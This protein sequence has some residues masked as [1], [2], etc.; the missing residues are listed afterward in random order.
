MLKEK[1]VVKKVYRVKRDDRKDKSSNLNSINEKLIDM[2]STLA[3]NAKDEEKL[4]IDP[5][6]AKSEQKKLKKQKNKE[7]LLLSKIEA[8]PSRPLG[9][10]NWQKKKLQKLSAQ[11]LKKK[12]MAWVPKQSIQTQSRDDVQAKGAAQLKEKR[13]FERQSPKLRFTPNHQNYWSL[14][15]PF[16]L[17][18][19]YVPISWNSSLDMFGY[20]SHTHFDPWVPHGSL[21]H[22][23]LSPSCYAR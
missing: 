9:L 19:P 1:K 4:A 15:Y 13:K 23:G 12:G 14:P 7:R 20:L 10:S 5:P 6:N 21:H 2:L 22:G 16:A 18:M 11:K 8:R 3:S 17:Q